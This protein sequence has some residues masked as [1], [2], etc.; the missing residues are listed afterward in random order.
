[1]GDSGRE[2]VSEKKI[3]AVM[4]MQKIEVASIEAA[5]SLTP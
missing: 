1:V 4:E 3:F 5:L 2:Q